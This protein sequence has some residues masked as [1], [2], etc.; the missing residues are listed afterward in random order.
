MSNTANWAYTAKATLWRASGRDEYGKYKFMSPVVILCDYGMDKTTRTE[1][2]GIGFTAKNTFY[3][4]YDLAKA[5]DY[6]ALGEITELDP[7]KAGADA[8][9]HIIRY[10]D[11]FDRRAD[12]Y[13]LITAV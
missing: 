13:V 7:I 9:K 8:I 4:E 2:V 6:I 1:A 5:G 3:T 10:A 11:T 12:D